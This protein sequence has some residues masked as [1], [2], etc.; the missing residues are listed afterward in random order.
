MH[1]RLLKRVSASDRCPA[2]LWS[3]LIRSYFDRTYFV[4]R[5][6]TD[7]DANPFHLKRKF[8]SIEKVKRV[9]LWRPHFM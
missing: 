1:D 2:P 9:F 8:G 7:F 6:D 5:P 3:P 4:F